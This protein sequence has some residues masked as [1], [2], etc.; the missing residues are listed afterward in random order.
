M[1]PH[2]GQEQRRNERALYA[3]VFGGN[4]FTWNEF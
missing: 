2:L 4:A 3:M 1:A